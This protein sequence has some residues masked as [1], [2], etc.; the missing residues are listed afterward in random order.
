MKHFSATRVVLP[1]L[2]PFLWRT[3]V[4]PEVCKGNNQWNVRVKF[5]RSLQRRCQ[6]LCGQLVATDSP[7]YA[8]VFK[9][10]SSSSGSDCEKFHCFIIWRRILLIRC[11]RLSAGC[12]CKRLSDA[13]ASHSVHTSAFTISEPRSWEP[14]LHKSGV[15]PSC[16]MRL[17]NNL[18]LVA[19]CFSWSC[20]S[21]STSEANISKPSKARR[22]S[23]GATERREEIKREIASMDRAINCGCRKRSR[24]KCWGTATRSRG[25]HSSAFSC[26]ASQIS[27]SC[28]LWTEEV[29]LANAIKTLRRSPKLKSL[30]CPLKCWRKGAR[31]ESAGKPNRSSASMAVTSDFTPA[32]K[33]NDRINSS[34]KALWWNRASAIDQRI[35][36]MSWGASSA[37]LGTN[38]QRKNKNTGKFKQTWQ[39]LPT[40]APVNFSQCFSI[41]INFSRL[42]SAYLHIRRHGSSRMNQ[43]IWPVGHRQ[44]QNKLQSIY[45]QS[46]G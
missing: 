15:D 1:S 3:H 33:D 16:S 26:M 37:C 44:N 14:M 32:L 2:R 6:D 29:H 7:H 21:P 5:T 18:H 46:I 27:R 13:S 10:I 41:S 23:S 8:A 38:F 12:C 28:S 11:D 4:T 19:K 31:R 35:D 45:D 22:T 30:H 43:C 24:P 42:L 39:F 20:I 36:A 9:T 40:Y 34:T 25:S 17:L